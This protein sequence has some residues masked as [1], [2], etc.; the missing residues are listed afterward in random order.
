[1]A[2]VVWAF[3]EGTEDC[4]PWTDGDTSVGELRVSNPPC[5]FLVLGAIRE[6]GGWA[7]GVTDAEAEAALDLV[8][9]V[10]GLSLCP[11]G[12]AAVAALDRLSHE[13][14][15][16]PGSRVVILN[17]GTGLLAGRPGPVEVPVVK[18]DEPLP[19]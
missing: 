12:A 1:C 9:S 2:P 5:G 19:L 11:E 4:R 14:I 10:E 16:S 15:I 17:T 13:G 7:V 3:A 8:A 6:S 18:P